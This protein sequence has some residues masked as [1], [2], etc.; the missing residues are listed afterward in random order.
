VLCLNNTRI[1]EIPITVPKRTYGHSKMRVHDMVASLQ[2]LVTLFLRSFRY[3]ARI[4]ELN[5][6]KAPHAGS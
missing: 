1:K 6:A 4:R 2:R 3:K 5:N